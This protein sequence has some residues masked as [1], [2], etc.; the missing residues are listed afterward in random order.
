MIAALT[1]IG[2]G[3]SAPCDAPAAWRSERAGV[4][5]TRSAHRAPQG[6]SDSVRAVRRRELSTFPRTRT[7]PDGSHDAIGG[8]PVA[9][10]SERAPLLPTRRA[11]GEAQGDSDGSLTVIARVPAARLRELARFP[12]SRPARPSRRCD[13]DRSLAALAGARGGALEAPPT[14]AGVP[15]DALEAPAVQ[16][17]PPL[18]GPGSPAANHASPGENA[19]EPR[20]KAP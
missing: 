11:R 17:F 7:V 3:R 10:E 20:Q 18:G 2:L 16:E 9:H 14:L 8:S 4:F 12:G 1:A 6:A 19:V 5:P 15:G 13:N